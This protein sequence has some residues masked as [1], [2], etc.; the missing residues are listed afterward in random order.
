MKYLNDTNDERQ[1]PEIPESIREL[2]SVGLEMKLHMVQHHAQ[3]AFLLAGELLND[4]LVYLTGPEAR[5]RQ[6][7]RRP[8]SALGHESRLGSHR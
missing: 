1:T 7:A 5:A 2:M 6:A 8:L 3:L 4:E